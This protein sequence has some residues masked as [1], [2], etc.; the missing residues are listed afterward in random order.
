MNKQKNILWLLFALIP[1]MQTMLHAEADYI[2]NPTNFNIPDD[3]LYPSVDDL[4][5]N[6]TEEQI[7]QQIQDAQKLFDSL[8]PEEMEEFAKI[9]DETWA[10]MPS[11]DKE[12]IQDIANMVK[13]YFP[14]PEE[15]PAPEPTQEPVVAA[16]KIS[17][18]ESNSVQDLIDNINAQID[19]V[20]QKISSNKDLIEEFTIRWSRKITFDNL[21]RKILTLK[22]DRLAEKLV[23][24]AN[25]EDKELI[26]KLEEFY[27]DLKAK[28]DVFYVEDTF[29]LPSSSKSQD[30]K[31]LKQLRE[32]LVIFDQGIDETEPKIE[33][34][35]K[36]HD[37]EALEMAKESAE[38]AKRAQAHAKEA[39]IKRGSASAPITP[40]PTRKVTT[41]AQ[42]STGSPSY[43]SGY[44]DS[45]AP[46][47]GNY[48]YGNYDYG[49]SGSGHDYPTANAPQSKKT[50]SKKEN[51]KKDDNKKT[52]DKQEEKKTISFTPYDEATDALEGY[53]ESVD[54]KKHEKILN[55]L[56][57]DL[58]N[59]PKATDRTGTVARPITQQDWLYS[60][61][62][63]DNWF[64]GSGEFAKKTGFKAYVNHAKDMINTYSDDIDR[65]QETSNKIEKAIPL[66]SEAELKKL[67]EDKSLKKLLD[68]AK[69]YL[70]DLD[71][72]YVKI[73]K[74][75]ADNQ[76]TVLTF[77]TDTYLADYQKLHSDFENDL[78]AFKKDL[79]KAK[80]SIQDVYKK[81]KR[82][83]RKNK[84]AAEK[85]S[86]KANQI[87]F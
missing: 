45:Y 20:L 21:K 15:Q 38:R 62:E 30:A 37:P 87:N 66:L 49:S 31:Q 29:G 63:F 12:A 61:G 35:L 85:E 54:N 44:Y 81:I 72:A 11:S 33:I 56:E 73:R 28:N 69:T 14:E 70:D 6:M 2:K 4:F 57:K 75:Q 32:I 86:K 68:R 59:Y 36:K 82:Y 46:Y 43:N 22:E 53:F 17:V 9:V 7:V 8:S 65:I 3:M 80:D 77:L 16:K 51:E 48:G 42:P 27:K 13:P 24:K 71:K 25:V 19:N 34:F 52:T 78:D 74:Q 23:T 83:Q 79:F 50:D 58:T 64:K 39:T 55:F 47:S 41:S 67:A 60:T 10:K 76:D 1:C 26:E 84:A 40:E 18:K 5:G